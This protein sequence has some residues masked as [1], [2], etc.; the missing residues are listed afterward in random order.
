M[1]VTLAKIAER[2]T[3]MGRGLL[4]SPPPGH[5]YSPIV[6]K[7]DMRR[8][9]NQ[10]FAPPARHLSGLDLNEAGQTGTAHRIRGVLQRNSFQKQ[11]AGKLPVLLR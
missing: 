5:F 11:E 10:L 1:Q 2:L 4:L 3:G 6:D 9:A 7:A 8:R